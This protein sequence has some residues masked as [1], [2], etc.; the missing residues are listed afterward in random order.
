MVIWYTIR[1]E[2]TH[3]SKITHD[4]R[5]RKTDPLKPSREIKRE[6]ENLDISKRKHTS[7]NAQLLQPHSLSNPNQDSD[8]HGSHIFTFKSTLQK[9]WV[10]T[11][12]DRCFGAKNYRTAL[13]RVRDSHNIQNLSYCN[14]KYST[15][16]EHQTRINSFGAV[17]S[18]I[19][20]WKYKIPWS[21]PPSLEELPPGIGR[22]VAPEPPGL[23]T[24]AC[25]RVERLL[26]LDQAQ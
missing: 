21:Y 18:S 14:W 17:R 19:S 2:P 20:K 9:V 3:D 16:L 26:Q 22:G 10:P 11:S 6:D 1:V 4:S 8:W 23:L 12:P 5:R 25:S 15:Y 24:T 13:W 7:S